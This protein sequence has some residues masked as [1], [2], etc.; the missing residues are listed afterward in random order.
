M[1]IGLSEILLTRTYIA[2]RVLYR[3]GVGPQ[4]LWLALQS[5]EKYLKAILLYNDRLTKGLSHDIEKSF[6]K[7][8]E[9]SDISFQFPHELPKF[10]AYVNQQGINRYF[11]FAAYAL[12]D[13]LQKL[14]ST[15]WHIRRYCKYLR[16]YST[17]DQ[18]GMRIPLSESEIAT[19]RSFQIK[20]SN[21]FRIPGGLLENAL[22]NKESDLRKH[23]VWKNS[24]YGTYKKK[25]IRIRRRSWSKN[26]APVL[27]PEILTILE[28]RVDSKVI[29]QLIKENRNEKNE[30]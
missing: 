6:Q 22:E 18:T 28:Q 13:E 29:R 17:P 26:P 25:I 21:K 15:V 19:I 9:I 24:Y 12:G 7:I 1:L 4:F 3:Y 16:G 8:K 20:D 14:D 11:E 10:I 27:Y 30:S 2:A 23:L 5:I